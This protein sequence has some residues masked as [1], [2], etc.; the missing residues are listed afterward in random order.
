MENLYLKTIELCDEE[1]VVNYLKECVVSSGAIK[2][3]RFEDGLDFVGLY[4][5]LEEY[6]KIPCESY[7]QKDYPTFQYLLVRREDNKAVG[8]VEIRPFLTEH[9]DKEFEGNVGYGILPSERGKGYANMALTLAMKK[10]YELTKNKSLILCCYKENIPSRKV[11]EKHGGKLIE[12][13]SGVLSA[14]KYKIEIG[15]NYD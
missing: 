10:Y 9:L 12:E 13:V 7:T 8:A 4:N 11:I 6:K 14:Q 15:D 5:K 2:G 1:S 3:F